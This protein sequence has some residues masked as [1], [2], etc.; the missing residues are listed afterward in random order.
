VGRCVCVLVYR[1]R[2][3]SGSLCR[4]VCAGVLVCVSMYPV[5]LEEPK[6]QLW[7]GVSVYVCLCALV[8]VGIYVCVSRVYRCVSVCRSVCVPICIVKKYNK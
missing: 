7:G 8:L 3:R 4:G 6:Q 5:H 2:E 1:K